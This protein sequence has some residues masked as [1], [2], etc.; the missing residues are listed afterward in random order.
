MSSNLRLFSYRL[1]RSDNLSDAKCRALNALCVFLN[2][3]PRFGDTIDISS[4][5]SLVNDE[6][7]RNPDFKFDWDQHYEV[8]EASIGEFEWSV[9]LDEEC[10]KTFK[11]FLSW[12]R[13]G[14]KKERVYLFDRIFP[15][16][17]YKVKKEYISEFL[18]A[19][20]K[21][22][23]GT[24]SE[25]ETKE[26][27]IKS[28][29]ITGRKIVRGNGWSRFFYYNV[30]SDYYKLFVDS[31]TF[32]IRD[33]SDLQTVADAIAHIQN[34]MLHDCTYFAKFVNYSGI[35]CLLMGSGEEWTVYSLGMK[36]SVNI[37]GQSMKDVEKIAREEIERIVKLSQ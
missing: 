1:D 36:N 5:I 15:E 37:H 26:E 32:Y 10:L 25:P 27:P 28:E 29:E 34:D 31:K 11:E 8:I 20:K 33:F 13:G 30:C 4:L 22:I 21:A 6:Q 16:L 3:E 7:S 12:T 24:D 2:S 19:D 9:S 18:K 35:T 23:L 14:S 17:P